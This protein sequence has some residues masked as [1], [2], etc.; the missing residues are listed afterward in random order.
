MN[1]VLSSLCTDKHLYPQSVFSESNELIDINGERLY[2]GTI[3]WVYILLNRKISAILSHISLP[4]T[5]PSFKLRLLYRHLLCEFHLTF[6]PLLREV[7]HEKSLSH[8]VPYHVG[9]A[10]RQK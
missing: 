7:H 10:C 8:P 3:P 6:F 9:W 1:G 4:S 5:K 2:R